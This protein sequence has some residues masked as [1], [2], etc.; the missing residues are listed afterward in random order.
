MTRQERAAKRHDV[1]R[2]ENEI[3]RQRF[4]PSWSHYFDVAANIREIRM[5]EV[6]RA[7]VALSN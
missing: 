6:E 5:R 2:Q 4:H 7:L 1:R 3:L